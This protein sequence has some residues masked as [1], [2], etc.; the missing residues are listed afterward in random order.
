MTE[1]APGRL[2]SIRDVVR[3]VVRVALLAALVAA[4]RWAW[5]AT[6]D[7]LL[8]LYIFLFCLFLSARILEWPSPTWWGW[9][10][11]DE[12]KRD[13]G[14]RHFDRTYSRNDTVNKLSEF[15]AARAF[16]VSSA[17]QEN[18]ERLCN[19]Y[20]DG[21]IMRA[22]GFGLTAL[23]IGFQNA[24]GAM[25]AQEGLPAVFKTLGLLLPF[26]LTLTWDFSRFERQRLWNREVRPP[27]ADVSNKPV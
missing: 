11:L 13:W 16:I 1:Q 21:L 4:E 14:K 10:R 17:Y 12:V 18:T 2:K 27:P 26:A 22:A 24:N 15:T 25:A 8:L 7:V 23:F 19:Q 5:I 6:H 3:F 20:Q 9:G